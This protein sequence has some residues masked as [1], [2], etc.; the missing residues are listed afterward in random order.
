MTAKAYISLLIVCL[1]VGISSISAQI[2]A[3]TSVGSFSTTYTNGAPD[4]SIY[5]FCANGTDTMTGELIANPTTP[6]TNLTFEWQKYDSTVFNYITFQ[7][8]S[9]LSSSTLS[10]LGS[11]GYKVQIKDAQGSTIECHIAWVFVNRLQINIDSLGVGCPGDT[12]LNATFAGTPDFVYFNPP[13]E[14]FIIDANTDITVC[15]DATHTFVSDLG[16]V[17][18][19]PAACGNPGVTLAPHPQVI[20]PLNG[21]CCNSF[22]DVNNL[23]FSTTSNT[24]FV[25]CD[26]TTNYVMPPPFTGTYEFYQ[27][28]VFGGNYPTGTVADLYGCNAALGDWRVQIYDCVAMDFGVLQGVTLTFSTTTNDGC[29]S[30]VQVTYSSSN[31][32]SPINDNSCNT[33]TASVFTVPLSNSNTTPIVYDYSTLSNDFIN[34][35]NSFLWSTNNGTAVLNP[36]SSLNTSLAN[37]PSQ[38]TWIYLTATDHLGC[39]FTDSVF[40]DYDP[41]QVDSTIIVNS[42]CFDAADGSITIFELWA[43]EFSLDNSP[44]SNNPNFNGLDT[45]IYTLVARDTSG[46]CIDTFQFNITE[47]DSMEATIVTVGTNCHN[48]CDGTG[49]IAISG[50]TSPYSYQWSPSHPDTNKIDS[51]CDGKYFV[52][53]TDSL[54]CLLDTNFTISSP[55]PFIFVTDSDSSICGIGTG[56]AVI[57]INAGGNPPYTYAWD[58]PNNS[59]DSI[60]TG[61]LGGTYTVTITDNLGCDSIAQVTVP[62]PELPIL[63]IVPND[64]TL[65]DGDSTLVQSFISMGQAPYVYHWDNSWTGPGPFYYTNQL[66]K[67]FEVYVLDRNNCSSDTVSRCINFF[68]PLEA[69]ILGPGG[70]CTG[71]TVLLESQISGGDTT[72][73]HIFIWSTGGSQS[74]ESAV[75]FGEYPETDTVTLVVSDGCSVDD[76]AQ[77]I[78]GFAIPAVAEIIPVEPL[79]CYPPEVLFAPVTSADSGVWI[80]EE[81]QKSPLVNDQNN[82]VKFGDP[83]NYDLMLVVFNAA[84][85]PDTAETQICVREPDE[86]FIPDVFSPNNNGFN[87]LFKI[88]VNNLESGLL[89]IYNRWGQKVYS[90]TDLS[91][92]W[93]GTSGGLKAPSGIYIYRLKYT[94]DGNTNEIQ[95]DFTL[96]R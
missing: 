86:I 56:L 51:L 93:D 87:D 71:D 52:T 91:E 58:D 31:V 26:W 49:E 67:C 79:D 69:E 12:L 76:T 68:D 50:G 90:T 25:L 73:N 77:I 36:G 29:Q 7:S 42:T 66:S 16:F 78:M 96:L 19:G 54:G 30:S 1:F 11:G 13:P 27:G 17:L 34:N 45:G 60:I 35:N 83:G 10:N 94:V 82:T 92:G 44:W 61:V 75:F 89:T 33:A 39:T 53:V 3:P 84:G 24:P 15:F 37:A 23:C 55:A 5:Y 18:W 32:N 74:T 41:P 4:D 20:D 62:S 63:A 14:P 85:C 38:D 9:G 72:A 28:N 46:S 22:N 81:S 21:C 43:A 80:V 59:T 64:T 95:G 2:T 65:C 88:Y 40:Y 70:I 8:F 48:S 57:T 47:P 6:G